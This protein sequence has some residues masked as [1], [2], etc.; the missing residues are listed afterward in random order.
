MSSVSE[1]VSRMVAARAE[2]FAAQDKLEEV[3]GRELDVL[4]LEAAIDAT[5]AGRKAVSD[6]EAA[7]IILSAAGA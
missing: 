3:L 4:A 7:R 6:P 5:H 1:I 2:Q